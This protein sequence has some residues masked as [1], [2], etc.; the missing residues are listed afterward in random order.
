[1]TAGG[2]LSNL[3]DQYYGPLYRFAYSLTASEAD[4]CDL[5]QETFYVW[6]RKGHQLQQPTKVKSWLFTTLHRQ[7]LQA[8]RHSNRFPEVAFETAEAE[9]PTVAAARTAEL[10]AHLVARLIAQLDAAF[11]SAVAL[12]YLEDY[13]YAEIAEILELPVGTVKSRLSRG[14]AQLRHLMANDLTAGWK[15]SRD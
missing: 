6:M 1:M 12:F 5:V 8:R 3:V 9:L 13:A 2:D 15:E 7:F 14:V 4:A 11:Q 10:D